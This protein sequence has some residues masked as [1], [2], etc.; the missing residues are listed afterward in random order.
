M[1]KEIHLF[2][3]RKA[4]FSA[5]TASGVKPAEVYQ[6]IPSIWKQ[7]NDWRQNHEKADTGESK[8]DPV[9][10]NTANLKSKIE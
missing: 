7:A 1:S 2:Q 10:S 6:D 4:V 5:S 3:W 8:R 9:K